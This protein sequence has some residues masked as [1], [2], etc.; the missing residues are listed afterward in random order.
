MKKIISFFSGVLLLLTLFVPVQANSVTL[1]MSAPASIEANQ[2]F[3][4]V[5][6]VSN[7]TNIA[8]LTA[9]LNYDSSKLQLVSSTGQSGF[10]ATVGTSIVLDTATPVS[11]SVNLV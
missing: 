4:V 11:G 10:A 3:N 8:G 7:T 2:Q 9:T 5:V 6:G 1:T